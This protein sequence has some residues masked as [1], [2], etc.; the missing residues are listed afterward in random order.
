MKKQAGKTTTI[1]I[2]TGMIEM[3]SG[4]ATVFG[5]DILTQM[6]EIR[7]NLGICP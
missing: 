4:S 5:K 7:T 3:S 6:S 1:S 2:L